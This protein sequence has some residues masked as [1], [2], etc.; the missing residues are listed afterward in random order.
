MSK[1]SKKCGLC[2]YTLCKN[3]PIHGEVYFAQDRN[4][5][6]ILVFNRDNM[7]HI[8]RFQCDDVGKSVKKII[9][10]SNKQKIKI[11][12]Y[13][14][15][16]VGFAAKSYFLDNRKKC[17]FKL[18]KSKTSLKSFLQVYGYVHPVNR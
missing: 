6:T 15:V 2:K 10:I 7:T 13:F 1:K 17:N 8:I 5:K 4:D 16:G 9:K 11:L 3:Q 12:S 18:K 14:P